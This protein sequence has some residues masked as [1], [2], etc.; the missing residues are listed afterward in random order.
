ML[1]LRD[2]RVHRNDFTLIYNLTQICVEHR[3]GWQALETKGGFTV[4]VLF[5]VPVGQLPFA[6]ERQ[7]VRACL[8]GIAEGASDSGYAHDPTVFCM[9]GDNETVIQRIET[10]LR[11]LVAY[12]QQFQ[13][14]ITKQ[15][16]PEPK[17]TMQHPSE[18]G[19]TGFQTDRPVAQASKS[20]QTAEPDFEADA[21]TT[22]PDKIRYNNCVKAARQGDSEAIAVMEAQLA[23]LKSWGLEQLPD[24]NLD[25]HSRGT[26]YR[27]IG[28]TEFDSLV[29]GVLIQSDRETHGGFRTDI[30]TN[31]NYGKVGHLGKYRLTFK[32]KDKFD[33]VL[34]SDPDRPHTQP[35][36]EAEREFHLYG[37]YTL[38]DVAEVHFNDG[39]GWKSIEFSKN[40]A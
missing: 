12:F 5:R 35:K 37:G 31:P 16:I 11:E 4:Q 19:A 28:K 23:T 14:A 22:D 20:P 24:I 34:R 6:E 21:I 17:V 9:R 33:P 29:S 10:K 25:W 39:D 18:Q 32:P 2:V 13:L 26:M 8:Y 27:I 40:P 3:L 30:T 38:A 36:N 15:I 1:N 7:Q